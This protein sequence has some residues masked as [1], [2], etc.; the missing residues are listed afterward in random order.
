MSLT[1]RQHRHL[2]YKDALQ[3]SPP[4]CPRVLLCGLPWSQVIFSLHSV[5]LPVQV[6]SWTSGH[7][8]AASANE[9][10][11]GKQLFLDPLQ[12]M[13]ETGPT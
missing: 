6:L 2:S 10:L 13:P 9:L 7:L 3:V 4:V 5:L 1:G 11:A 8:Q 12:E